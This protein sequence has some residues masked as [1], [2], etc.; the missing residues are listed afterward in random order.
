MPRRYY[1]F[2]LTSMSARVLAIQRA[3]YYQYL[4]ENRGFGLGFMFNS[5]Q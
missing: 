5:D 2:K 3:G 1:G 4:D